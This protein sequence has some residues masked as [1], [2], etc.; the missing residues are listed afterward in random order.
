MSHYQLWMPA[1]KSPWLKAS[2]WM[3]KQQGNYHNFFLNLWAEYHRKVVTDSDLVIPPLFGPIAV[4]HWLPVP[5]W[6]H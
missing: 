6:L 5:Q 1:L 4:A 2:T 3:E